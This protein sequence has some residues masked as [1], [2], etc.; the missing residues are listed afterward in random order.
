MWWKLKSLSEKA[1]LKN[2]K[3]LQ[4]VYSSASSRTIDGAEKSFQLLPEGDV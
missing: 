3:L 1:F 2:S 4:E